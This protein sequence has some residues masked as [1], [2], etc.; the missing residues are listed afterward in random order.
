MNLGVVLLCRE[1]VFMIECLFLLL[2]ISDS[3]GYDLSVSWCLILCLELPNAK[4]VT[5]CKRPIFHEFEAD[6]FG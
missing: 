1:H 4:F 2:G 6:C 5:R 3:I